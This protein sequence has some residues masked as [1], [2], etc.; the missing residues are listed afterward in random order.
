MCLE[1]RDETRRI[2][3]IIDVIDNRIAI[4]IKIYEYI[5]IKVITWK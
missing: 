5:G 1:G 2:I 4:K 3:I